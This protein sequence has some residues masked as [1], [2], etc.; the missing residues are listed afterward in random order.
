MP[1]EPMINSYLLIKY[2]SLWFSYLYLEFSFSTLL[3]TLSKLCKWNMYSLVT[4][5]N[6]RVWSTVTEHMIV[7][8]TAGFRVS[9]W[10]YTVWFQRRAGQAWSN[11]TINLITSWR[12]LNFK[13]KRY[14]KFLKNGYGREKCTKLNTAS[15]HTHLSENYSSVC[16]FYSFLFHNNRGDVLPRRNIM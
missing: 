4:K 15:M 10:F 1:L 14:K 16:L 8:L 3:K 2:T 13:F 11:E 12:N 5:I 7:V 6:P 9:W